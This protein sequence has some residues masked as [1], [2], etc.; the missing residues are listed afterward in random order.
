MVCQYIEGRLV[1]GML[2][3]TKAGSHKDVVIPDLCLDLRDNCPHTTQ[4][5]TS[6][7]VPQGVKVRVAKVGNH[8]WSTIS[9]HVSIPTVAGSRYTL[10]LLD[11]V[12]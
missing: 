12:S 11:S 2:P 1:E 7:I 9:G 10:M 5:I 3:V 6:I 8:E 4:F